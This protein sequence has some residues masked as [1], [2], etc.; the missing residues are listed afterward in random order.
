[1]L[2]FAINETSEHVLIAVY[3]LFTRNYTH[4]KREVHYVH[5]RISFSIINC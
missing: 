1:M 2:L 5:V 4:Q 3:S